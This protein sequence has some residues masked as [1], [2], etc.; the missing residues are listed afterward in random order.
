MILKTVP[1]N[2]CNRAPNFG[3]IADFGANCAPAG[4]KYGKSHISEVN[5]ALILKTMPLN[6][7]NRALN[8]DAITDFGA[9]VEPAT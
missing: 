7:T 8:F 6:S 9:D 2:S 4:M 3:A 1:S 5:I